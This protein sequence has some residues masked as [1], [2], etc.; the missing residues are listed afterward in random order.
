MKLVGGKPPGTNLLL[1]E[2]TPDEREVLLTVREFDTETG[3][4]LEYLTKDGRLVQPKVARRR[5]LLSYVL[6]DSET[7]ERWSP[8]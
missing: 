6:R 7:M 4:V 2:V 8:P 3:E 1:F 5:T